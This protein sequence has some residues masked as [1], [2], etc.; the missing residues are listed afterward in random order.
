MCDIAFP[1][2]TELF[3]S[4]GGKKNQNQEKTQPKPLPPTDVAMR[5]ESPNV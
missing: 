1:E 4:L 5:T 3:S 2:R